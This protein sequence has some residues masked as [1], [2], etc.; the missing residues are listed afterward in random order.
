MCDASVCGFGVLAR[1]HC[2]RRMSAIVLLQE[3]KSKLGDTPVLQVGMGADFLVKMYRCGE[4][5]PEGR[6]SD[7]GHCFGCLGYRG[8]EFGMLCFRGSWLVVL[9][10]GIDGW[11]IND[12]SKEAGFSKFQAA[13]IRGMRRCNRRRTRQSYYRS[14]IQ[15]DEQ[16]TTGETCSSSI[17]NALSILIRFKG[18]GDSERVTRYAKRAARATSTQM[19]AARRALQ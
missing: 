12:Y 10:A 5:L 18:I 17:R 6:I 9:T 14:E 3:M 1:S 2:L 15:S 8:F 4:A 7:A 11:C 19:S 16:S 13:G